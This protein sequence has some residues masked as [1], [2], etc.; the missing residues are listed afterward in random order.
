MNP[1]V[2]GILTS[3]GCIVAFVPMAGI[4]TIW[5]LPV[6]IAQAW[7]RGEKRF[8]KWFKRCFKATLALLGISVLALL[9][10]ISWPIMRIISS[11]IGISSTFIGLVLKGI[12][13]VLKG[14]LVILSFISSKVFAN[15]A[16]ILILACIGIWATGMWDSVFFF[17]GSFWNRIWNSGESIHISQ[18]VFEILLPLLLELCL[19]ITFFVCYWPKLT[20]LYKRKTQQRLNSKLIDAVEYGNRDLV[21]KILD[22]GAQVDARDLKDWTPLHIAATYGNTDTAR[23]LL[24]RGAQ[25]DARTPHGLTP[26]HHAANNCR[27]DTV[28]LLLDRGAQVDAKDINGWTPFRFTVQRGGDRRVAR[29]LIHHGADPF[30]ALRGPGDIIGFFDGDIDWMP[31]DIKAKLKDYL[32]RLEDDLQRLEQALDAVKDEKHQKISNE[33]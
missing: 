30:K 12:G 27:R 22:R 24:D 3:I 32:Q 26:L 19:L 21:K 23:L 20:S 6:L 15:I 1:V 14:L 11:I 5:S 25:V 17:I 31:E 28:M 10:A 18:N 33:N 2:L 8:S 29:L 4:M 13:L 16:S 9:I 7:R